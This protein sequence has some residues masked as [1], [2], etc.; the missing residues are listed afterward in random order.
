MLLF[1][2]V[3]YIVIINLIYFYK[4]ITRPHNKLSEN[5]EK[6]EKEE[7]RHLQK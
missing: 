5:L 1:L 2:T 7:K 3:T 6:W 4:W